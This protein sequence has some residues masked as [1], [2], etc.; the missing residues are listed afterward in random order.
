MLLKICKHTTA[1]KPKSV[2]E[3]QMNSK[4]EFRT[5]LT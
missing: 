3:K 1:Q 4:E 2:K 5:V